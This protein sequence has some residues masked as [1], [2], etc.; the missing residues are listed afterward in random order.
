MLAEK[1]IDLG[2]AARQCEACEM[3]LSCLRDLKS[4]IGSPDRKIGSDQNLGL[5]GRPGG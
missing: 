3:G 5:A 4:A 2:A 1:R